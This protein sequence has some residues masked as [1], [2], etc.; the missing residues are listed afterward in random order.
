M[1]TMIA[2]IGSCLYSIVDVIGVGANVA[3]PN[4]FKVS[5]V[6]KEEN[7]PEVTSEADIKLKEDES[8]SIADG[9][10]GSDFEE[11][12]E[13][14]ERKSTGVSVYTQSDLS[15]MGMLSAIGDTG[16]ENSLQ[17][18]STIFYILKSYTV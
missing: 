15:R 1:I 5:A 7:P 12:V 8:L 6:Q 3:Q 17:T 9:S 16:T 10:E 18:T 2:F 14:R 4:R 13:F 11:P